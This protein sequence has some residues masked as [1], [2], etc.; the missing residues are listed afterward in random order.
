MKS[1][2]ALAALGADMKTLDRNRSFGVVS[3]G[4]SAFEQDGIM[5]DAS[6]NALTDGPIA[7]DETVV[8]R[9]RPRKTAVEDQIAA[10][11]E[12]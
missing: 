10:Q 9:G 12:V 4:E 3:G 11:A 8:K 6:G 1:L 7:D 2:D 5:F